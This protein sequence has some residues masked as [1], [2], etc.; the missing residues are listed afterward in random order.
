MVATSTTESEQVFERYLRS[1]ELQWTRV[2]S[3]NGKH[4]DYSV[5]YK[6]KTCFFEV[7]EF[8]DPLKKPVG[9]FSPCPAMRE[10]I[11]QARKQFKKYRNHCCVLVLW[12]S[13]S[14]YRGVFPDV[15]ASAAF[16]DFIHADKSAAEN[17]RADPPRYWFS[18]PAELTPVQNTTISA[19]AI[20]CPYR[21]NHLWL[22]VWRALDAK[23][24]RGEE[25]TVVDQFD[26]LQQFSSERPVTYSYEGTIRMIVLENPYA[27][28]P[29]RT[30]LFRGPFD[31]RWCM[32]SGLFGVSFIGSELELLREEGVPF[33]Y[34]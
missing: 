2:E 9:G 11:T 32:R 21:L 19:I 26:F 10:K 14:I 22:D 25:V 7:K 16:G 23:Q 17:L 28:I 15:V 8:D 30:N 12:N 13:K 20:L 27:R 6:G 1:Q 33:V 3:A 5:E 34:L 31:Q 4:P 29:L 24:R 18:G